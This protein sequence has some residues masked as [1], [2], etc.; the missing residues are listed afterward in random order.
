MKRWLMPLALAACARPAPA[1]PAANRATLLVAA[2]RSD[3]TDVVRQLLDGGVSPDTIATD[4]TRPLTE[5]ARNGRVAAAQVLLDGG[6]RIDLA[7]S[8]GSQ[9]LDY[10]MEDGHRAIAALII[11][12]AAQDAGANAATMAWFD[13]LAD[14]T[15]SPGDWRR[16]LDGELASLGLDAAV[17]AGRDN[18]V[19]SLR[20]AAGLPNRTGYG[21]LALAARFGD[22]SAVADLLSANANPDAEVYGHWHETPLMEAARDGQVTVARRLLHAG[23]RVDHTDRRRQTALMWAVREGETDFARL[24]LDAGANPALHDADGETALDIA[25]GIKHADLITLL[26]ARAAVGVR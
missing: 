24:L 5:A 22:D 6:A 2:V 10:A 20:H 13:A 19:A 15:R 23:A 21:P 7:D 3:S 25:R 12:Q 1:P 4:G 11:R 18:T 14:S 9:P 8:S 17:L 16:L 26:E